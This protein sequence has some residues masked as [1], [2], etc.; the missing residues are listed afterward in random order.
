MKENPKFSA[1]IKNLV[2]KII[3]SPKSFVVTTEHFYTVCEINFLI[4]NFGAKYRR[5]S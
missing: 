2:F 1:S 4:P 3:L 5:Q